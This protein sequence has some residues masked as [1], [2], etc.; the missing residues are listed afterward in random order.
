MSE[1]PKAVDRSDFVSQVGAQLTIDPA[2][3]AV[4]TVDCHRGHL[5]PE[6]ATL[7]APPE[8]AAAVVENNARLCDF[9]RSRG[10]QVVHVI[11]TA[12]VIGGHSELLNNPF[13]GSVDAVKQKLTP[14]RESTLAR[15]NLPGSVQ[16]ELMPELGP[17]GNDIVIDTKHRLNSFD[18]TDLSMTLQQLGI[19]TVLLTGINTN[20]CVLN[21]AFEVNQRDMAAVVVS[22]CVGSMYGEDLHYFGLQNISR[23]IGWVM[24]VDEIEAR[25]EETSDMA[26]A[27]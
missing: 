15:H 26:A 16:V 19:E 23:C 10:I 22:D 25:L 6:V 9:A 1:V 12:R 4:V 8:V 24:S 20:T 5:D 17:T 3:T 13:F 14:D 7:P 2:R 27:T 21:A 18:G 11:F